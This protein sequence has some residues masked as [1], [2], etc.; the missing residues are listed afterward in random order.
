M[1]TEKVVKYV[2]MK[3]MT[4][5]EISDGVKTM[6]VKLSGMDG[7]LPVF[8]SYK[9]ALPISEKNYYPIITLDVLEEIDVLEEVAE[10]VADAEAE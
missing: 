4:D 6:S 8:N 5:V 7:Y 3:L 10:E 9:E 2:V 1:K